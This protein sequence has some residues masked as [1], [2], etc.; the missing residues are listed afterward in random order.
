A[1]T[2]ALH[3]PPNLVL[4]DF[5][6]PG[7][8]GIHTL[9]R[10]RVLP[11]GL[12]ARILVVSARAEEQERWRFSVLGVHDFLAKPVQLQDLVD[13][14]ARIARRSGFTSANEIPPSSQMA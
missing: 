4:L 1:L 13:T 14:V 8:D 9:S 6:M 5:D 3:N 11:G 12:E 2:S 10:L 7:L